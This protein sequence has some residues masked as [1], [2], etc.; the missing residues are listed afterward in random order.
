MKKKLFLLMLLCCGASVFAQAQGTIRFM[1][2][3]A[4]I[5]GTPNNIRIWCPP[6]YDKACI[7]LHTNVLESEDPIGTRVRIDILEDE[8]VVTTLSGRLDNMDNSNADEGN[9]ITLFC[10]DC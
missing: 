4:Y 10:E 2:K 7:T 1:G 5:S 6:P 3:K 9:F 8:R